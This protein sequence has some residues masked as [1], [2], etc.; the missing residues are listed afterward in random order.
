MTLLKVENLFKQYGSQVILENVNFEIKNGE[1]VGLVGRN[2]CGKTTLMKLIL[3]LASPTHGNIEK[4]DGVKFGFLL[5]CKVFEFL[6]G[7]ENLKLIGSYGPSSP[8][9]TRVEELLEF[10]GLPNDKRKVKDYSFGMKQRLSLALALLEEPDFLI[11]D[12]PFVGLDPVGVQSFIEYIQKIRSQ[13]GVTVLISSHQLSE[14]EGI[15]DYFLVIKD[16]KLQHY[17]EISQSNLCIWLSYIPD[18]VRLALS[19]FATVEK[20]IVL[21]AND[22]RK[23]SELFRIISKERL[24]ILKVT[25][26]KN[27]ENIFVR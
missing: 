20:N 16:R 5:D 27:L 4:K 3:G 21:I 15:C 11:L 7:A 2:G 8:L 17:V 13:L 19:D 22:D 18:K 25:V 10:V 6:S 26:E 12:E 23:L 14:I 1:I 9:V 24:T